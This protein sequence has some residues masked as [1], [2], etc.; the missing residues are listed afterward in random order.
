MVNIASAVS[1]ASVADL[2]GLSAAQVIN[3]LPHIFTNISRYTFLRYTPTKGVDERVRQG[4]GPDL[5][6]E[7]ARLEIDAPKL[8]G[9]IRGLAALTVAMTASS[10]EALEEMLRHDESRETN[11]EL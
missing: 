9:R 11:L 4:V 1:A 8:F 7:V 3:L 6:S 2:V 5:R 10:T